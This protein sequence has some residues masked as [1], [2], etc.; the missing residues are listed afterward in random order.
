MV[1]T[2]HQMLACVPNMDS[3][4]QFFSLV[5]LNIEVIPCST[6]DFPRLAT[7]PS[8]SVL[9]QDAITAVGMSGL[10]SWQQ[11]LQQYFNTRMG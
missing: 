10:R 6:A 3:Q 9:N 1:H 2:M 4:K 11:A 5:A 7:R 8:Y